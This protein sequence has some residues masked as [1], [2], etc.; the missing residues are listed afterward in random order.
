MFSP[1]LEHVGTQNPLPGDLLQLCL[2]YVNCG[3]SCWRGP[4]S[5]CPGTWHSFRPL[6][7]WGCRYLR[8]PVFPDC[9][10]E[11]RVGRAAAQRPWATLQIHVLL[12]HSP[13]TPP[14]CLEN[15]ALPSTRGPWHRGRR[16]L[17]CI[18]FFPSP[19]L[20]PQSRRLFLDRGDCLPPGL[21]LLLLLQRIFQTAARGMILNIKLSAPTPPLNPHRGFLMHPSYHLSPGHSPY[22]ALHGPALPDTP[23]SLLHA[24]PSGF[25][26]ATPRPPQPSPC[27]APRLCSCSSLFLV[28]CSH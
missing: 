21:P 2:L 8:F 17:S 3:H 16:H 13:L 22:L 15:P 12:S 10:P 23:A 1:P 5:R 27:P 19:G 28:H 24:H 14:A 9:S 6:W 18:H 20:P 26:P 4:A 25:L 11:M 7:W